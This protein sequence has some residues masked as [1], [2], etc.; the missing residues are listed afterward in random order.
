MT[1]LFSTSRGGV[2]GGEGKVAGTINDAIGDE[3]RRGR[4]AS[5]SKREAILICETN[6]IDE[7]LTGTRE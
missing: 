7:F 4:G 1:F 5:A 6:P 3:G 2:K